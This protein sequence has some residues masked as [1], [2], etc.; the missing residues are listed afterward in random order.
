MTQ[1]HTKLLVAGVVLAGAVG[2][3]AMAGVKSGWA[4]FVDVDKYVSDAQLHTQ[5]VRLHGIVAAD[6]FEMSPVRLTARFNLSG[7]QGTLP[8]EFHGNIPEL[9]GIGK[10]VV[11]EGRGDATGVFQ[12]DLLMTKCASKYEPG[13]PHSEKK[14]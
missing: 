1:I 5:R 6:G 14:P 10:S 13:S 4:Y 3:L 12:A 11:V 2:Y 7:K 8:V 9:F